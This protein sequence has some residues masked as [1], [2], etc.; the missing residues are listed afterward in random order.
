MPA[1]SSMI[2]ALVVPAVATTP[3]M[4]PSLA[5]TLESA[6]SKSAFVMA[7]PDV[8]T[9]SGSI[10]KIPSEFPIEECACLLSAIRTGRRLPPCRRCRP[11]SL[12]TVRAAKLAADPPETNVP[13]ADAGNPAT[14]AIQRKT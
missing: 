9:M 8:S 7:K 14:S 10:S 6:S 5:S 12:A 11:E 1:R 3:T 4:G 13:P 2:P